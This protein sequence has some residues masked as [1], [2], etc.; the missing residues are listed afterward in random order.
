MYLNVIVIFIHCARIVVVVITMAIPLIDDDDDN[1]GCSSNQMK[2]SVL[3]MWEIQSLNPFSW[4][5]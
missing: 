3:E 2:L 5:R 1:N 4:V